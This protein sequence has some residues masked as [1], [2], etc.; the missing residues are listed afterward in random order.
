MPASPEVCTSLA[1]AQQGGRRQILE[2]WL[3]N[4][5]VNL[6]MI[7]FFHIF[8]HYSCPKLLY[9]KKVLELDL[10][11][12]INILSEVAAHFAPGETG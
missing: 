3:T 12:T 10:S 5:I 2:K 9:F 6:F 4:F 1:D 8:I 11:V 7:L